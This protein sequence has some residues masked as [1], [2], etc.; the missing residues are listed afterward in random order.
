MAKIVETTFTV[1]LSQLIK[2]KGVI[3]DKTS[4][5]DLPATIE[6]VVQELVAD[7]VVVEVIK[8]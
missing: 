6:Q 2:D 3:S 8:N 5:D 1:K 7:D 4:F